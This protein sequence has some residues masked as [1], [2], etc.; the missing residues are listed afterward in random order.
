MGSDSLGHALWKCKCICGEII[1]TKGNYLL[2]GQKT[3]CGCLRQPNLQGTVFGRLV[4]LG[5]ATPDAKGNTR[6]VCKCRCGTKK[7]IRALD[8]K[9]GG[10]KSC[11]CLRKGPNQN[12]T[13]HG[14]YK[15]GKETSIHAIW[16]GMIQRC[17]NPKCKDWM[18]YG[19][20]GIKVCTRWKYSF[21]AFL[22]DVGPRPKNLTLDR[23]NNNGH[24][25][26]RNIRWATIS[27]QTL[28]QSRGRTIP[29]VDVK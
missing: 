28:N 21:E 11:G 26:P 2:T 20:R 22:H 6:L 29:F 23:T 13:T 24:Y 8:L 9:S 4:V 5:T 14:Q 17:T 15:G 19:G 10:T 1:H 12:T 18:K 27:Q 7:T 16:R 3:N 25:V